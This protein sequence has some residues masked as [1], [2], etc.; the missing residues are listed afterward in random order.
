M[1]YNV[2]GLMSGSSLD[3]LDIAFVELTEI[4]GNWT[5]DLQAAACIPYS[6]EWLTRL[7]QAPQMSVPDFL[8]LHTAYGRY[9]GDSVN[10][11]IESNQ[12]H[13]R[14]HFIAS[15]GHTVF[16]DPKTQT[17]FQLGDGASI[18]AITN[19]TVI[20]D[21]RNKDIALG[22]Q[23]A[24][25]VP[26]AD[27]MLWPSFQACLNIGGIA[28]ITINQDNPIAFDIC[29]ANQV[30]NYY[31]Q[32]AGKEYDDEGMMALEGIV[33]QS[34]L[35]QLST[36]DYYQQ[37]APKSLANTYSAELIALLNS[38]STHDALATM[39]AHIAMETKRALAPYIKEN[40][41]LLITGGGAFNKYLVAEI[42]AAI[43]EVSVIVPEEMTIQYKEA[44]AMALFG[45]LRW[46][47]EV[48][49]LNSVTG[50][51]KNSVGGALW[52]N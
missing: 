43:P 14:T 20:S 16:H 51:S 5:F 44:I 24:P 25:I 30:L 28:N 4:A 21:L 33:H 15:H 49:V 11:F 29:P 50:A 1:V 52:V 2:I 36:L 7:K 41:Q 48:N 39:V 46:R 23:G 31:A 13:H 38:L 32:Q 27:R 17:S 45:A 9:L 8:Q 22:G 47:E 19:L 10:E 37:S 3:G 6:E 26:I 35:S 34:V 42:Q 40:D 12:L 18:A